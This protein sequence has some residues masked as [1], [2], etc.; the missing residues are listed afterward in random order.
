M[1]ERQPTGRDGHSACLAGSKWI[2]FGGDRHHMPFNDTYV[3][4]LEQLIRD[5]VKILIIGKALIFFKGI[6][7]I[8]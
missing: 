1:A 4:D 2:I 8:F 3:L 5:W 6:L 7:S